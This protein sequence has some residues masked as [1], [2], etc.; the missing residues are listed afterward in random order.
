MGV[1]VIH[2]AKLLRR[3]LWSR[4]ELNSQALWSMASDRFQTMSI[5]LN[6]LREAIGFHIRVP[7]GL[8]DGWKRAATLHRRLQIR[9]DGGQLSLPLDE[10]SIV[11]EGSIDVSRAH[12]APRPVEDLFRVGPACFWPR[13]RSG[14]DWSRDWSSLGRRR[15]R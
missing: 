7:E 8:P 11:V 9:N 10:R 4:S 12:C 5:G 14:R 6:G 1:G 2:D 15:L 13:R 3:A